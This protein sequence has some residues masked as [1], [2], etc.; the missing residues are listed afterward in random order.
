LQKELPYLT[1]REGVTAA[2]DAIF[3]LQFLVAALLHRVIRV[4]PHSKDG[5]EY[6]EYVTGCEWVPQ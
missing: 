1:N 4:K 5:N 2:V 6:A 3:R